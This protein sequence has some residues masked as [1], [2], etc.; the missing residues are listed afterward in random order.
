MLGLMVGSLEKVEEV[1][2]EKKRVREELPMMTYLI[3]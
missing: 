2:W 3:R 1:K